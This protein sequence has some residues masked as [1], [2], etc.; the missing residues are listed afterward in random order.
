MNDINATL[1]EHESRTPAKK[2]LIC[3]A[4]LCLS[5]GL[6]A[7]AGCGSAT[8]GY[9][10][11]AIDI[12]KAGGSQ[13]DDTDVVGQLA[14]QQAASEAAAAEAQAAAEAAAAEAEAQ[15][16]AEAEAAQNYSGNTG[17]V[18]GSDGGSVAQSD[19]GCFTDVV[20]N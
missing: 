1:V 4:I 13:D 3:L 7:L 19:D 14:S 5:I 11:A 10:G 12:N 16:A 17:S 2:L 15:A 18:G 20:V 9:S 8:P 6:L